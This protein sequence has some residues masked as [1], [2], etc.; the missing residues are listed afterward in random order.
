MYSVAGQSTLKIC[1]MLVFSLLLAA[2][3]SVCTTARRH[4]VLAATA[5]VIYRAVRVVGGINVDRRLRIEDKKGAVE[6]RRR[7]TS[8]LRYILLT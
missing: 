4:S 2:A 8:N 7:A 5:T 1:L 6:K 3:L